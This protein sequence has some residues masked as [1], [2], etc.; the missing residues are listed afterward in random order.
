MMWRD[1]FNLNRPVDV[2]ASTDVEEIKDIKALDTSV[3]INRSISGQS[4]QVSSRKSKMSNRMSTGL[5]NQLSANKLCR[6]NEVETQLKL[7]N[8]QRQTPAKEYKSHESTYLQVEKSGRIGS[9][10]SIQ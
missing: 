3:D 4:N 10:T 5:Q 1:K 8:S 7:A 9:N 6:S 2:R